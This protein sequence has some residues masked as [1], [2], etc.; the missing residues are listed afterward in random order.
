MG[1]HVNLCRKILLV[2]TRLE[3][4]LRVELEL[5]LELKL[6]LELELELG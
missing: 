2:V 1:L 3:A 4:G 5:E 6:E